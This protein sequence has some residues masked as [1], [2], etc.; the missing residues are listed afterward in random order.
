[1]GL[2][3]GLWHQGRYMGWDN[4]M[5]S[6]KEVTGGQRELHNEVFHKLQSSTSTKQWMSEFHGTL[7]SSL[8]VTKPQPLN[9]HSDLCGEE[10]CWTTQYQHIRVF[11]DTYWGY[12]Y[13]KN[14]SE[15]CTCTVYN[16]STLYK[17]VLRH[18]LNY[19]LHDNVTI[20]IYFVLNFGAHWFWKTIKLKYK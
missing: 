11:S 15:S 4:R 10:N 19:F 2:K 6:R 3:L 17:R 7:R 20:N 13:V 8:V 18:R 14:I 9:M 1:M 5:L 16:T 12:W